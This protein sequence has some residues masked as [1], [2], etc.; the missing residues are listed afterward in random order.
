MCVCVFVY[1]R[2]RARSGAGLWNGPEGDKEPTAPAHSGNPRGGNSGGG[3]SARFPGRFYR[4][5]TRAC[6]PSFVHAQCDVYICIYKYINIVVYLYVFEYIARSFVQAQSKRIG[7]F[8]FPSSLHH[9]HHRRHVYSIWG[10]FYIPK[11]MICHRS[12]IV[13][14]FFI[15]FSNYIFYY[16][17][18][19]ISFFFFY[20]K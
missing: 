17:I 8:F 6:A 15:K 13:I 10:F 9:N 7:F 12:L 19:L 5:Y 18:S 3:P 4:L 20:L 11:N 2:T 16:L 1:M 14:E